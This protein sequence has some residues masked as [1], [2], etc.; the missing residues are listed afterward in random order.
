MKSAFLTLK[1]HPIIESRTI[2]H[3]KRLGVSELTMACLKRSLKGCKDVV[4]RGCK[5]VVVGVWGV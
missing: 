3:E 4:V 5:D 1:T 2:T